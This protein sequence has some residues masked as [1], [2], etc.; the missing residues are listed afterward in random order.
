M[1][2]IIGVLHG[3]YNRFNKQTQKVCKLLICKGGG[4]SN[5]C[6]IYKFFLGKLGHSKFTP[7]PP[8]LKKTSK[9][10]K[11]HFLEF[12]IFY[13]YTSITYRQNCVS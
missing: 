7:T 12:S 4:K 8:G 6:K 1:G 9:K 11:T 13:L 10:Q 5:P 2:S 3:M